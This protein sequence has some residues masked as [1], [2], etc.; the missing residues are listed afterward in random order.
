[1]QITIS[2][3]AVMTIP[4][5]RISPPICD[6]LTR[7]IGVLSLNDTPLGIKFGNIIRD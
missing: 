3:D 4:G 6:E 1:M 5:T 2:C 7:R